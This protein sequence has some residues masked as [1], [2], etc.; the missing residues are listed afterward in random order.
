MDFMMIGEAVDKE[1]MDFIVLREAADTKNNEFIMFRETHLRKTRR[2]QETRKPGNLTADKETIDFI[3]PKETVDKE[4]IDFIVLRETVDKETID[5]SV[6]RI[7]ELS[8]IMNLRN[9]R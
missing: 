9:C 7:K 8:D 1:P 3:M 4:S 5:F 2:H 6:L